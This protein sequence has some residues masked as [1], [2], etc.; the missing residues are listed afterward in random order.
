VKDVIR[1]PSSS[2]KNLHF[3]YDAMG[4]RVSKQILDN[5]NNLLYTDYYVRDAQGN[6]MAIYRDSNDNMFAQASFRIKERDVYGN[7]RTGLD[8]NSTELIGASAPDTDTYVRTLGN[9]QYEESNHLGNVLA[10]VSDKKLPHD[11]DLDGNTDRFSAEILS[12]TDY[13]PFGVPLKGREFS[14]EKYRYGFNG[15]EKDD[16]MHNNG[17]DS[18]DFGA[19]MLD[20]RLGR[21]LST[22][23]AFKK[24]P[25]IAPYVAF[26]NNP[27]Y[28]V[29]PGGETLRVAQSDQSKYMHDLR[30]V[31]GRDAKKYFTFDDHNNLTLTHAG[32]T[33][34][35]DEIDK[36]TNRGQLYA[37]ILK[38]MT[39]DR[40]TN[41]IYVKHDQIMMDPQ[42]G[43]YYKAKD[44][45]GNLI[46][47]DEMK[48]DDSGGEGTV[49]ANPPYPRPGFVGVTENTIFVDKR[50]GNV[51]AEGSHGEKLKANRAERL[52]HGMGHVIFRKNSEQPQVIDFEDKA[53]IEEGKKPIKNYT[54][55]TAG[56]DE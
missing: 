9:K 51:T 37:G 12:S 44:T 43:D 50:R 18:Y 4:N 17:G 47:A 35:F 31:F 33:E 7:K 16:E 48:L 22:D 5:S 32:V 34:V 13:S 6:V 55:H 14:S 23:P 46:A 20:V 56:K 26:G 1:K 29:D 52:F 54:Q 53:R 40:T 11:D 30:R 19:R 25:Q 42:T 45:G 8:Q 24:Y 15:K 21:W 41:V 38:I 28:F 39:Q 3:D 27:L 10:V 49:L 2:K 36:G